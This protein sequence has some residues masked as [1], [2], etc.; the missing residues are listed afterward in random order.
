MHQRKEKQWQKVKDQ[1]YQ[2]IHQHHKEVQKFNHLGRSSNVHQI[3]NTNRNTIEIPIQD[4]LINVTINDEISSRAQSGNRRPNFNCNACGFTFQNSREFDIHFGY[5]GAIRTN[6][7]MHNRLSE[8][9]HLVNSLNRHLQGDGRLSLLQML[10]REEPEEAFDY[11]D[12]EYSKSDK[13]T[14]WKKIGIVNLN[15]KDSH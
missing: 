5:C 15:S 10:G 13:E 11:F 3:T 2:F 9:L 12:W 8:I 4:D 1:I 6:N 14:I 7:M